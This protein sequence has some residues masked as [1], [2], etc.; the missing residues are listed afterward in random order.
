MGLTY[1]QWIVAI[2]TATILGFSFY[3]IDVHIGLDFISVAAGF[4]CCFII[5]LVGEYAGVFD[6]EHS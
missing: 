1:E 4:L 6:D 2:V 5:M 3:I